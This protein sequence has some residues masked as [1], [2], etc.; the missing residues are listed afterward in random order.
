MQEYTI[1][2]EIP[3]TFDK[4][5]LKIP[6]ELKRKGFTVLSA[7]RIDNLFEKN[8]GVEFQKYA[9]FCVSNLPLM[10]HALQHDIKSG[11]LNVFNFIVCE[12]SGG[13][14]TGTIKLTT[15]SSSIEDEYLRDGAEIIEKK[16]NE[17][18]NNICNNKLTEKEL[19][20][21]K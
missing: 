6:H 8:L 9:I 12:K 11:M 10:Y 1:T 21:C 17:V 16:L 2:R 13:T 14:V 19:T 4:I 15:L 7:T 18:L 3:V 20:Q 5:F